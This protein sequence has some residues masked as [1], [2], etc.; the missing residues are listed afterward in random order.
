MRILIQKRGDTCGVRDVMM[1]SS[2]LEPVFKAECETGPSGA[3]GNRIACRFEEGAAST[4]NL[5]NERGRNGGLEEKGRRDVLALALFEA[6]GCQRDRQQ[7]ASR[8]RSSHA[9]SMWKSQSLLHG[10]SPQA[11]TRPATW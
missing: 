9:G 5:R 1:A 8:G 3:A 10:T 6:A 7:L 11:S 2:L 4:T